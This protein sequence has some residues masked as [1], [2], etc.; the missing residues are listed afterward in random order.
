MTSIDFRQ[1][2]EVSPFCKI[3]INR[4]QQLVWSNRAW[5][6]YTGGDRSQ[7]LPATFAVHEEDQSAL[8]KALSQTFEKP[9]LLTKELR[10][11][12]H[13]GEYRRFQLVCSPYLQQEQTIG[14]VCA[15]SDITDQMMV[16][17]QMLTLNDSLEEMVEAR[18]ADLQRAN[19]EL[20]QS[21]SQVLQQEKM[22]SIGQLAA[23]V[24]HEINNP[25]GFITS[26][27]N[28]LGKYLQRFNVYIG[29]QEQLLAERLNA[30]ERVELKAERKKQKIDYLLEDGEDL[31][32]ESLDGAKRVQDIVRNLKSF[33][34]VDQAELQSAD[35]NECLESTI[36]IAWNE[37]KYKVTLEKDYGDLPLLQCR[38]QQLNQV[39]MN[40]LLNSA[41]AIA[42]K[43]MIS[44]KTWHDEHAIYVEISD[45]GCGIPPENLCRIFEPFFTTK[46]VGKGTGLGMSISYDI[47]AAHNG[48]ISVRSE[49]GEGTAFTVC[50]SLAAESCVIKPQG[51]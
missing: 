43:G 50:L 6:V 24:A 27:L 11:R 48:E 51:G 25:L 14:L 39:F 38:P 2:A 10:Y 1:L 18:T 13:D 35:L 33:S 44:V 36:A 32:A 28:S 26:N 15:L 40:L 4:Q 42:D 20:K 30:E 3:F 45:N 22:A 12:R 21:Q 8:A 9:R 29:Y 5:E 37:L 16:E 23:G 47:I 49:V 31:L 19:Q 46:E 17:E 34:R 7:R 41:Q